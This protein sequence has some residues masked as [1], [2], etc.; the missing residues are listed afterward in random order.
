MQ[1]KFI[2]LSFV[3]D[4]RERKQKRYVENLFKDLSGQTDLVSVELSD[5]VTI[6]PEYAFKGCKHLKYVKAKGVRRIEKGAF[7][8]CEDLEDVSISRT[9]LL[10]VGRGVFEDCYKFRDT[11]A[12]HFCCGIV[13]FLSLLDPYYDNVVKD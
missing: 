6:I 3:I 12:Y 4:G 9:K 1:D 10:Y 11:D 5:N 7:C 13:N 2:I 8:G